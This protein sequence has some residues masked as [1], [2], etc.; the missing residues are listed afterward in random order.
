MALKCPVLCLLIPPFPHPRT[1][2]TTDPF[3]VPI[4]L[5]YRVFRFLEELVTFEICT[6]YHNIE[7]LQCIFFSIFRVYSQVVQR[8]GEYLH[9]PVN[10]VCNK[11]FI[12]SITY[13]FHKS[14]D[15]CCTFL[16]AGHCNIPKSGEIIRPGG[17]GM[18][19]D[20]K[21][22]VLVRRTPPFVEHVPCAAWCESPLDALSHV[23]FTTKP[24]E[25]GAMIIPVSDPRNQD[26]SKASQVVNGELRLGP[27]LLP[28]LKPEL[29]P[30][31]H[32]A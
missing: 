22:R 5:P 7:A 4:V 27:P 19:W 20:G 16:C 29:L 15:I 13:S 12:H 9:Y 31:L 1:G 24:Q 32:T 3:T 25:G 2:A 28:A 18:Q 30:L 14:T 10:L 6:D 17:E 11:I 26:F 23:M 21:Y 8:K